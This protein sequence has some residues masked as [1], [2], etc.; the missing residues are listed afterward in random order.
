MSFICVTLAP[1]LSLTHRFC[2]FDLLIGC[3]HSLSLSLPPSPCVVL[4]GPSFQL[5]ATG[6]VIDRYGPKGLLLLSVDLGLWAIH[7]A[8]S[9]PCDEED[10]VP[11]VSLVRTKLPLSVSIYLQQSLDTYSAYGATPYRDA[12]ALMAAHSKCTTDFALQLTICDKLQSLS[13]T[14]LQCSFDCHQVTRLRSLGLPWVACPLLHLNHKRGTLSLLANVLFYSS[15]SLEM[16]SGSG[17]AFPLCTLPPS[18]S[19]SLVCPFI[20]LSAYLATNFG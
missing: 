1:T 11:P 2:T 5:A 14:F 15:I 4:V 10:E 9:A 18:L 7:L 20:S 8:I 19:R 12:N 17:P 13:L 3:S 6:L 16:V